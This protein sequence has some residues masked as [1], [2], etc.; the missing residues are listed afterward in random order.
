MNMEYVPLLYRFGMIDKSQAAI[1]GEIMY[2]VTLL[3]TQKEWSKVA[4]FVHIQYFFNILV[5]WHVYKTCLLDEFVVLV[6]YQFFVLK[7]CVYRPIMFQI[8]CLMD[9]TAILFHSLKT[10]LAVLSIIISWTA[11]MKLLLKFILSFFEM[12]I[13]ARL[14]TSGIFPFTTVL[15]LALFVDKLKSVKYFFVYNYQTTL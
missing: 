3:I 5:S 15:F 7:K 10:S 6:L 14:Y 1:F 4:A 13:F 11:L 8:M 12:K 9:Y 2:Q